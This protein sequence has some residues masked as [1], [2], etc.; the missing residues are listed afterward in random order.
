VN[1]LLQ[2]SMRAAMPMMASRLNG[3]AARSFS[4][5]YDIKSKFE[6]AYNQKVEAQAK[7]AVKIPQPKNK[8]EY[9]QAYYNDA[10]LSNMK[11][12]YVHPY[13]CEGSPIY[14]SNSY[15]MKNLFQATGPE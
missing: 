1:N 6:L 12:G 2:R 10:R 7:V 8:A 5:A 15:F 11:V 14:M 4:V 13:H 9:G 3:T